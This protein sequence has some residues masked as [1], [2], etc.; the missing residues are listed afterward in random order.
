MPPLFELLSRLLPALRDGSSRRDDDRWDTWET[1][2]EVLA[3]T[4]TLTSATRVLDVLSLLRPQDGIRCYVTVNPGSAFTA[5]LDAYLDSLPGITV[6][7]WREA[8][9]R[10]FDVAV[11]CTVNRSM[12]RLRPTPLLVLPHGVGYN[13]LVGP[14]TGDSHSPA[15]LSRQ[16]L[17]W[18]GEVVPEVIC[19]SHP[20][21]AERLARSCPVEHQ[22][23][24]PPSAGD[25]DHAVGGQQGPYLGRVLRVVHEHQQP[26]PGG[27]RTEQL[28]A[29]G[30]RARY[31]VL[32]HA[33]RA[34]GV[35]ERLAQIDPTLVAGRPQIGVQAAV[36]QQALRAVRPL[37][38]HRAAR[39][40]AT[41]ARP[42][43]TGRRRTDCSVTRAQCAAA[44]GM[45]TACRRRPERAVGRAR[46]GSD[47]C[48]LSLH[49]GVRRGVVAG[50]VAQFR[51]YL[52]E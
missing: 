6:L 37:G 36:R 27:D 49:S 22:P 8:T 25:H 51:P 43:P 32:V 18:R 44:E 17:T 3:V 48:G 30:H 7:S 26:P 13:R 28:A 16:E 52:G 21:Q 20:E 2:A 45:S 10:T 29:L 47:G 9:R 38:D 15:G 19:L 5:G 34:E 40:T 35:P 33:E 23:V 31:V 14:T 12:H 42:G 11:A 46:F 41:A 39:A 4:R 24:Q 1:R 50:G